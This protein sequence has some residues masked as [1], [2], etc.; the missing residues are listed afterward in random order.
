MFDYKRILPKKCEDGW[1]CFFSTHEP[2][3]EVPGKEHLRLKNGF[4]VPGGLNDD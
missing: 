1:K 3:S 2:K 4:T